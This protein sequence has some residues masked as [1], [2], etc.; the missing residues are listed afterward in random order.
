MDKNKIRKDIE[1]LIDNIKEHFDNA[2][3][4]DHIP[5]LELESIVSKIERLHKKAIIF[6]YLNNLHYLNNKRQ[7]T[8][9]DISSSLAET[10]LLATEPAHKVPVPEI[11]NNSKNRVAV[12]IRSLIGINE[13]F[14]F[15]NEL[16]EGNVNEYTAAINQL[17]TYPS[18]QEAEAYLNSIKSI[19]NWKD[20]EPLVEKFLVIVGR[21]LK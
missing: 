10:G 7:E 20:E 12:D 3:D 15:I 8:N 18:Y 11:K 9:K 17:N 16:F 2:L 1:G 19:Y 4:H 5:L 14:Q 13:K 6:H 21:K